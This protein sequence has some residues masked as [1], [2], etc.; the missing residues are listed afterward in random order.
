MSFHLAESLASVLLPGWL[1]E[2]RDNQLC[3]QML[4]VGFWGNSVES[5][6]NVYIKKL[7]IRIIF[8]LTFN[9]SCKYLQYI[10][11]NFLFNPTTVFSKI[12]IP[13]IL[14]RKKRV[15]TISC[16]QIKSLRT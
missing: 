12:T 2:L 9:Q 16:T 1:L 6:K 10:N 15:V 4:M 14:M 8:H 13:M 3:V 5:L 7:M 11:F